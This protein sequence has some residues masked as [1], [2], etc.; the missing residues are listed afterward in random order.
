MALYEVDVP[1]LKWSGFNVNFPADFP[2]LRKR[3][4]YEEETVFNRTECRGIEQ[5]VDK[6]SLDKIVL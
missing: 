3:I 6:L 1:R 2:D 5:A 4:C